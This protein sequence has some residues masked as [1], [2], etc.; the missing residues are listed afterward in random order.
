MGA[1]E[2]PEDLPTD[3]DDVERMVMESNRALDTATHDV[4]APDGARDLVRSWVFSMLKSR[5]L[6]TSWGLT[7]PDFQR[8]LTQI[9]LEMTR[10]NISVADPEHRH[11]VE[12]FSQ[13]ERLT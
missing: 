6:R 11:F 4:N 8:R 3:F 1:P 9:W 2:S 13:S 7:H 10:G 5:S 12:R